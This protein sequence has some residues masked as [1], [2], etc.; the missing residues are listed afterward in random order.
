MGRK[1]F[2]SYNVCDAAVTIPNIAGS[3]NS[4][5]FQHHFTSIEV[6]DSA[7]FKAL[8]GQDSQFK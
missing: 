1:V 7:C 2:W 5:W 6:Q 3:E 4:S 8:P